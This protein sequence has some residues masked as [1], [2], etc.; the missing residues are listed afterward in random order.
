ME[1]TITKLT[2]ENIAPYLPY[3]LKRRLYGNFPIIEGNENIVDDIRTVAFDDPKLI[4]QLIEWDTA[5]PLLFP[6]SSL[7]KEITVDGKTFVP[8][9]ELAKIAF[10]K[11]N[12]NN[13]GFA[14]NGHFEKYHFYISKGVFVMRVNDK[15]KVPSPN[16]LTL[17]KKMYEWKIDVENLIDAGLALPVTENNLYN[18]TI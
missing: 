4:R 7:T 2:L 17:F 13:K 12:W 11:K 1:N 5:K 16:Q 10:P 14:S 6:L 18:R 9:V 3:G 15:V 8:I